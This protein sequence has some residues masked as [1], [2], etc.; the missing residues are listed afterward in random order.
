MPCSQCSAKVQNERSHTH[1]RSSEASESGVRD[2]VG[3]AQPPTNINV[4]YV[5]AILDL[6]EC[7][8]YDTTADVTRV[9]G[10]GVQIGIERQYLAFIS[11]PNPP[12]DEEW[13][14]LAGNLNVFRAV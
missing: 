14:T 7:A 6:G 11:E 3:L 13:M 12:I 4:W 8:V 9:T 10:V 1:L 2:G 5:K